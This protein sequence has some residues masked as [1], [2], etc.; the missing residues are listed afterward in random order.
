MRA[1]PV[2]DSLLRRR[3]G[4]GTFRPELLMSSSATPSVS[5]PLSPEA[6]E[7]LGRFDSLW[8][9][10]QRP[11]IDAFLAECPR[12]QRL[13]VLVELIHSELEY[14]LR[15]GEAARVEEYLARYPE[16]VARPEVV[17]DLVAA[18]FRQRYRHDPSHATDE[19]QQRFPEQSPLLDRLMREVVVANEVES[20]LTPPPAPPCIDRLIRE[21]VVACE[22]TVTPLGNAS[23]S[24][25]TA[26]GDSRTTVPALPDYELLEVLGQGGMGAVYR[27]RDPGL[28]RDLALKVLRP[29]FQGVRPVEERFEQEARITGSLQHPGIVPVYNLGRLPDGRL[30]F[31]MKIVRGRTLAEMLNV[32]PASSRPTE[33]EAASWKPAPQELLAIFEKVCQTLAYAHSK[34]VIHRDLKPGNVMVGAF[35]EV[36]VMDW[37]LAKALP[38]DAAQPEATNV[39]ISAVVTGR[40]ADA[41]MLSRAGNV[42]GTYAYMAPEQA[43]GAVEQLDERCDVF[44]LGAVLCEVLTGQPPYT[45]PTAPVVLD[46]AKRAELGPAITRLEGCGADMELIALAKHCLAVEPADRPGNAGE[47]ARAVSAYLAGVQQRLRQAE[48]ERTAAEARA[49]EATKKVAAERRARRL[50]L[51]LAAAGLVVVALATA[52]VVYRQQQRQH[53]RERAEAGLEQ[54]AKLRDGFHYPEAKDLLEHVRGWARQAAHGE[55]DA[56]LQ[57]AEEDLSLARDLD[58]VR[59]KGAIVVD[60]KWGAARKRADYPELLARHGLDVLEGDL[61]EMS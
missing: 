51:G 48:L 46:R 52:G 55:L 16:L 35:G 43:G 30:Y 60:G 59:Q 42:M 24:K 22:T 20:D 58:D 61:D 9:K 36:Q 7:L 25:R 3:L 18:E 2:V 32:G 14:R 26:P 29:E 27:S 49:A 31:T 33:A 21:V 23:E 38:R 37:G 54:V 11:A 13:A 44:G 53:A 17:A 28:G 15:A 39:P 45:G 56:M 6:K 40:D 41:P 50:L 19:Y 34:R 8:Q 5:L 47:V 12:E 10:Q 57:R 4:A 1:E